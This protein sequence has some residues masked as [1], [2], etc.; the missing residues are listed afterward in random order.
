MEC[1]IW[2]HVK[3]KALYMFQMAAGPQRGKIKWT[4]QKG[5]IRAHTITLLRSVVFIESNGS[6]SER[7]ER[8]RDLEAHR[9]VSSESSGLTCW[10]EGFWKVVLCYLFTARAEWVVTS[11]S[12]M[13]PWHVRVRETLGGNRFW[14]L[15]R[16]L[17]SLMWLHT[18]GL[19]LHTCTQEMD[20][21]STVV[22]N[23]EHIQAASFFLPFL[24]LFFFS[25]D[26]PVCNVRILYLSLYP[27]I[28]LC[29]SVA[30]TG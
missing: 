7:N 25:S 21:H 6:R 26:L 4:A 8:L 11:S 15:T 28:T 2:R 9:H 29:S 22:K 18:L 10:M 30:L 12:V 5:G 3:T 19:D 16:E 20:W 17:L 24:L 13:N 27:G 14:H 23:Y 1:V